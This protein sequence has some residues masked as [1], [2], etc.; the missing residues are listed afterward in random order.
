MPNSTA[1]RWMPDNA[2]FYHVAYGLALAIYL[3]YAISLGRRIR[4]LNDHK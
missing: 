1:E 2:G 4:R 3:L